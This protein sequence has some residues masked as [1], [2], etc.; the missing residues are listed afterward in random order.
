MNA[1]ILLTVA[2]S[3]L[4]S[5]WRGTR[6]PWETTPGPFVTISREAGTGGASLAKLVARKL[7]P[8]ISSDVFWHIYEANLTIK[9]LRANQLPTRIA[10]FLP[11]DR[12]PELQSAIGEMVGLHPSL[13]DLVQKTNETM[14]QLAGEG[15]TILVGRG[16]NFA[17]VNL[18][19][20]VHVRLVAPASHRAKYLAQ[21]Y[22]ISEEAAFGHNARCDAARRR[23]VSAN[24]NAD[25]SDPMAYDLVIN[26]AKVSLP[27]AAELVAAHV[28][29]R[30]IAPV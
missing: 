12:V 6:N 16:A 2:D 1:K 9:M 5:E 17:T 28:R 18:P 24:F 27:E 15:R 19:H 25:V 7:N 11:E 8:E 29:A 21:L 22:G 26:M 3:Y 20:G 4:N 23:Y 14:R 13:W 30:T 10:R